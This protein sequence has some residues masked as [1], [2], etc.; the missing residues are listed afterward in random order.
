MDEPIDVLCRC[1]QHRHVPR[2]QHCADLVLGTARCAGGHARGQ[3]RCRRT[4]SQIFRRSPRCWRQKS[5]MWMLRQCHLQG[6]KQ[7]CRIS[8]CRARRSFYYTILFTMLIHMIT[9]KTFRCSILRFQTL[10]FLWPNSVSRSTVFHTFSMFEVPGLF[11]LG[12][13]C[14]EVFLAFWPCPP[15]WFK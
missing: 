11:K 6:A 4:A 1:R 8:D 14:W 10:R 2:L 5:R 3:E 13:R 12:A 9:V 15:A 7:K